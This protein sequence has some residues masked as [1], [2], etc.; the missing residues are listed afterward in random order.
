M[1]TPVT[2]IIYAD[3]ATT[4]VKCRLTL[5]GLMLQGLMLVMGK[6]E[7]VIVENIRL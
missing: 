4:A 7:I 6:K 1:S 5:G 3:D 2:S